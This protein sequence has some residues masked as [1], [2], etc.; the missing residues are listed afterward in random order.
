M[1]PIKIS[2][3]I[4][5]T[6]RASEKESG[7]LKEIEFLGQAHR[8]GVDIVWA[9]E[10]WAADGVSPLAYLAALNPGMTCGTSI[11]QLSARTP[12]V[13][14]MTAM[15]LATLTGNR[16]ILGL[17]VSGP[18]VVEG[19]HSQKFDN[20][21]GRM[22]E[23]L[24][25]VRLAFSGQKLQYQGRHYTLPV[26]GGEGKA[27]RL[28]QVPNP[29]IPIHLATLG[30][31]ML[32]MTGELADGWLG[33]S[34]TPETADVYF[35]RF[36]AG[37]ARSGRSL[38]KFDVKI[39]VACAIGDD[40]EPLIAA[41]KMRLAFSLGGMGSAKTNFYNA[42]YRRIGYEDAAA[43]VQ[44]LFVRG[45]R[46]EAARRVPD[47]MVLRTN[48]IGTEAMVRERIRK[49]RDAG[50]TIL[51]LTPLAEGNAERLDQLGRT[52]ELIRQETGATAAA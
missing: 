35:D 10:A 48:L 13:T 1:A 49:Y 14:A 34:F 19:L 30:P 39:G 28:G 33:S 36:R 18:Q 44:A 25:I 24:D 16:F 52:I 40:P 4:G 46:E 3:G 29:D 23:Y 51:H 8:L 27:I 21:L 41:H 11:L 45:E 22:R 12:V 2:T 43:E 47:E 9:A 7:L 17:G 37:A 42:A 20:P 32:E 31:K 15:T 38:D 6:S 50:V 5:G 26:P